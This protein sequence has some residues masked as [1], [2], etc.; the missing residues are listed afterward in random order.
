M[1]TKANSNPSSRKIKQPTKKSSR[2]SSTAPRLPDLNRPKSKD[3][4]GRAL[5]RWRQSTLIGPNQDSVSQELK[6]F[7]PGLLGDCAY[8]ILSESMLP[9]GQPLE[10]AALGAVSFQE[11]M[12][13]NDGLER[14]AL[15]QALAAHARAAW[16]TQRLTAQTN[17]KSLGIISEACERA[18]GTF[19]RLMR[20]IA[21]YRQP[22]TSGATVAIG[23]A[24]LAHQQVV[25]TIQ[26]QELQGK[27]DDERTKITRKG[28]A[29]T[30]KIVS[31]DAERVQVTA[32]RHP[33]DTTM[34]EKYGP[35]DS[36]RQGPSQDERTKTRRAL[37][38]SRRPQATDE[39]NDSKTVQPRG[40]PRRTMKHSD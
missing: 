39:D 22:R 28:A 24:N 16:L 2:I 33:T 31:A 30:A 21:E 11:Q 8:I 10:A 40:G 36:G 35:Q 6:N 18:A 14:L 4:S 27:N 19:V 37:R 23:Q 17:P 7:P 13:P 29:V 20:A 32:G 3:C 1:T 38:R 34:D 25:Q 15:T 9:S 5:E 26:K 12:R